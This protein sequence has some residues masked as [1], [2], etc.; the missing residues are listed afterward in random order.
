L[1]LKFKFKIITIARTGAE[2][3]MNLRVAYVNCVIEAGPNVLRGREEHNRLNWI[4]SLS[5]GDTGG[6]VEC[7]LLI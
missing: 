1:K 6:G 3:R 7:V 4:R 2:T 5:N